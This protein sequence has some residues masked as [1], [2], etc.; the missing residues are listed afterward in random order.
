MANGA[1]KNKKVEDR[2]HVSFFMKGIEH[3]SRD[4]TDPFGNNPYESSRRDTVNKRFERHQHTE[5]HTDKTKCFEIGMLLQ[6]DKTN[7]RSCDG[8]KP[9]K[10]KEAPSPINGILNIKQ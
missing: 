2:M 8:T 3:G 7:N 10:R 9:D 1:C 4:I 5:S 6:T